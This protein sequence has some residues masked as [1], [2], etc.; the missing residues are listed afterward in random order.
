VS[1]DGWRKVSQ[2]TREAFYASVR[3]EWREDI[4]EAVIDILRD[5]ETPAPALVAER[6]VACQHYRAAIHG[7]VLTPQGWI[8]KACAEAAPSTPIEGDGSGRT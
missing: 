1:A 5:A 8:C 2:E 3:E 4:A 7:G 6:I